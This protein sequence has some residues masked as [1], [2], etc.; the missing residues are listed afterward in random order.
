MTDP[1]PPVALPPAGNQGALA[2]RLREHV[3]LLDLAHDAILARDA[4]GE[5][6]ILFW[7]DGAAALYG[8]A[9]EEAIGRRS[10]ELLHTAPAGGAAADM[11]AVDDALRRDGRWEGKLRRTCKDGRCIV[12]ES[13]KRLVR[14]DGNGAAAPY[15]LEIDRDVTRRREH[16]DHVLAEAARALAASLETDATLRTV[17]QLALPTLAD[18][19]VVDVVA[20]DGRLRRLAEAH[21]DPAK[22]AVLAATARHYP[23]DD[24]LGHPLRAT[25]DDRAP[26]LVATVDDAFVRAAAPTPEHRADVESL[27]PCSLVVAPLTARGAPLGVISFVRAD[28]AAGGTG[29]RYGPDDVPLLEEL[30]RHA[31]LAIENARLYEAER[32]ARGE[33]ERAAARV[34]EQAAE[35]EAA[36]AR[37]QEQTAELERRTATAQ[38]IAAELEVTAEELRGAVVAAEAA[39]RA[40]SDFLATMSHEIRTPINAILGFNELLELGVAGPLTAEQHGY[41]ERVRS[42]GRHLL[43]IVNEL[44]DLATVEAGRLAVRRRPGRLRAAVEPA[45]DLVRPQAAVRSLRLDVRCGDDATYLGDE[46]RVRQIVVNLLANAVKFTEP[47]GRVTVTCGSETTADGRRAVVRIEDSGIGIAAEQLESIFEPFVQVERGYTRRRGGA[48]LG[49]SISRRLATVMGGALSAE[50][51]QGQGSIFTL[52]LP[53]PE[54]RVV[55]R[56]AAGAAP[57]RTGVELAAVG[58]LLTAGMVTTIVRVVTDR[59][60]ADPAT[61]VARDLDDAIVEDHLGTILRDVGRLLVYVEDAE[62][63]DAQSRDAL[64]DLLADGTEI[65]RVIAERHGAQR[66]RHGWTEAALVRELQIVQQEVAAAVRRVAPADAGRTVERSVAMLQRFLDRAEAIS[67]D[68]FRRARGGA[69]P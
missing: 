58:E 5:R 57:A 54:P 66:A 35:L 37:L 63:G 23:R 43:G 13:R 29:G 55:A 21:V 26:H 52:R 65:Q 28:P 27:A 62:K 18:F 47:G 50:S 32:A 53:M 33:A 38:A 24:A 16:A 48:G 30:A 20:A 17:A 56:P 3:A 51:V 60:R 46:D 12:T 6:R 10:D 45:V 42:S 11:A 25:L 39:N 15:V 64:A 34:R 44:L 31:A 2:D 61:A 59:L 1:P 4:G 7:S 14:P 40:K 49:L 19:C 9:A 69:E 67:I 41:L 22:E 8:H 68:G 36:N